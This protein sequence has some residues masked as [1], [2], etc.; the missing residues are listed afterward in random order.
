MI[1]HELGWY[2]ESFVPINIVRY[3]FVG[4]EDFLFIQK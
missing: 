2:H 4:M 3:M 1:S